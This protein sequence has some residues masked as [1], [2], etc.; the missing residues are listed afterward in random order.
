M[1]DNISFIVCYS[2]K[3]ILVVLSSDNFGKMLF[4]VTKQAKL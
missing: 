3:S 4:D 1:L 2:L